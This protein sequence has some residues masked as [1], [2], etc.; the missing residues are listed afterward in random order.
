[1]AGATIAGAALAAGGAAMMSGATNAAG[2]ADAFKAAS[3]G[4]GSE[5]GSGNSTPINNTSSGVKQNGGA[6]LASAMGDSDT[7]NQG[8]SSSSKSS[9]LA[10]TAGRLA[11]GFSQV[12]QAKAAESKQ[13]FQDQVKETLGGKMAAAIRASD[14]SAQSVNTNIMETP[15]TEN[16][17]ASSELPSDPDPSEFEEFINRSA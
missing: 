7:G 17:L 14:A 5:G 8:S 9:S 6:A 11:S 16:I 4:D 13:A 10:N 12:Q 15:D 2:L 1:M 3:S